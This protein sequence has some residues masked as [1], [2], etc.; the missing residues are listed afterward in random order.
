TPKTTALPFGFGR[1]LPLNFPSRAGRFQSVG[2]SKSLENT[3]SA[4]CG[5]HD[6]LQD[7]FG[8]VLTHHFSFA[9]LPNPRG[10]LTP[11]RPKLQLAIAQ[12]VAPL[13]PPGIAPSALPF[14]FRAVPAGQQL[15]KSEGLHSLQFCLY[16][17]HSLQNIRGVSGEAAGIHVGSVSFLRLCDLQPGR[18][19][20]R[21]PW[22]ELG[23][24]RV[25][26]C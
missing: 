25:C 26:E 8:R 19:V 1:F 20:R 11:S 14:G 22:Y 17:R 3:T 21:R 6:L 9:L 12:R 18:A 10:H 4:P 15:A 2:A 7:A 13:I 5:D 23:G 24:Q 16:L